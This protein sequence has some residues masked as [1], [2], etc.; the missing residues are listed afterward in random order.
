MKLELIGLLCIIVRNRPI[1][2]STMV[3]AGL[4]QGRARVDFGAEIGVFRDV[5]EWLS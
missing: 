5:S 1:D 2:A 4:A 3:G